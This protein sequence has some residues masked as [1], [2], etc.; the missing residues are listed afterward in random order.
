MIY[1]CVWAATGQVQEPSVLRGERLRQRSREEPQAC[2]GQQ[3]EGCYLPWWDGQPVQMP[4]SVL[5][6]AQLLK[7]CFRYLLLASSHEDGDMFNLITSLPG[8]FAP[9]IPIS[10]PQ[11]CVCEREIKSSMG[12]PALYLCNSSRTIMLR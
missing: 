6:C 2:Q 3:G 12:L 10:I 5:L 8:H 11:L 4:A 7:T 9:T 1:V